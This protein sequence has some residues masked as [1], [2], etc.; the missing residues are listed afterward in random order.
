MK[1]GIIGAMDVEVEALRGQ[2][3][4]TRTEVVSGMR[5]DEGRL[6]GHDLVVA[7]A[8]VGK[9][10]AA[11]CAQTM[12]LRSHPDL[13]INTGVAGGIGKGLQVLDVVLATAVV[14]HDMDPS[15]LGDPV[16]FLPAIEKI[17]MPCDEALCESLQAAAARAG[18]AVKR[19]LVATG[20]QFIASKEQIARIHAHFDA[21]AAEMEGGAI[22]QV[23]TANGVPFAVLR[24]I[25]DGG[26]EEA[27]MSYPKFVDLASQRSLAILMEFLRG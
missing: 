27:K 4:G 2:V 19:G 1:I 10:A 6:L 9:V 8:G 23:C 26:N 3:E 11:M 16:G 20:D 15:P 12:V 21:L 14:Q 17:E 25:S 7:E 5:F 18:I 13:M 24:A 22:G